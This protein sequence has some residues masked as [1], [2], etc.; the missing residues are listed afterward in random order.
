MTKIIVGRGVRI[1]RRSLPVGNRLSVIK[2]GVEK[3]ESESPVTLPRGM[4]YAPDIR[5]I[6]VGKHISVAGKYRRPD[7]RI[8]HI[9]HYRRTD[10][11]AIHTGRISI[12]A[13]EFP[14]EIHPVWWIGDENFGMQGMD[15][16]TTIT[17]VNRHVI[18]L[19]VRIHRRS[20]SRGTTAWAAFTDEKSIRRKA[21]C[22]PSS[23]RPRRASGDH[24]GRPSQGFG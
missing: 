1:Q 14:G 7:H 11:G 3:S 8:N 9:A 4:E 22:S 19:I 20:N 21:S 16:I 15:Q 5:R 17:V 10:L 2:D 18:I 23:Q 6:R 13:T 24:S 12:P